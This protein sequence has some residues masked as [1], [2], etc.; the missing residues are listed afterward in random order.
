MI[1]LQ[2]TQHEAWVLKAARR[3][4]LFAP[5]AVG[6]L[7][8]WFLVPMIPIGILSV[9]LL[10]KTGTFGAIFNF[11]LGIGGLACV[12][13]WLFRWYFICVGLM[14]GRT[15]MAQSKQNE[16]SDRLERLVSPKAESETT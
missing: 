9:M 11:L 2:F 13:P 4:P 14:V 16:V 15:A 5:F 8:I 12:A 1:K 10:E 7:G 3:L 6:T